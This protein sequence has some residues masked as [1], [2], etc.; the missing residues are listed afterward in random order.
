MKSKT[1][2]QLYVD[3]G[4]SKSLSRPL[5]SNDNYYIESRFKTLKYCPSFPE[6]FG[7]VLNARA[8]CQEFFN[9]YNNQH[10]HSGIG[11]LH[12]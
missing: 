1:A 4:I 8:F 9:L 7:C 3:L 12:L 10:Y 2:A 5:V 6:T 11:L